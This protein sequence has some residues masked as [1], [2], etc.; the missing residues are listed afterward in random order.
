MPKIFSKL[1]Q[2]VDEVLGEK[3]HGEPPQN[4]SKTSCLSI[5]D[6]VAFQTP[7]MVIMRSLM[8]ELSSAY[9]SVVSSIA[10][11]MRYTDVY[12]ELSMS[13]KIAL[14]FVGMDDMRKLVNEMRSYQD[15]VLAALDRMEE[16]RA[17]VERRLNQPRDTSTA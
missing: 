14:N 7:E 13:D 9:Y 10:R 6:K 5:T 15:E 8:K 17:S 12:M 16:L 1:V 3:L 2:K 11:N 4:N